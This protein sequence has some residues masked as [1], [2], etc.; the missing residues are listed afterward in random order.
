MVGTPVLFVS[1]QQRRGADIPPK[2]SV[3]T[4]RRGAGA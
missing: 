3:R 2:T 1:I 4:G